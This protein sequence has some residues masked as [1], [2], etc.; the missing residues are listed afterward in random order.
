M[1][2]L[3]QRLGTLPQLS[4]WRVI[5]SSAQRSPTFVSGCPIEAAARRS[6][7][8]VILNGRPPLRPRARAGPVR[9]WCARRSARARTQ[10]ASRRSGTPVFG[11]S[12]GVDRGALPGEHLNPTPRAV[13]S[14]TVLTGWCRLRPSR[15]GF[16][17]TSVS[18][19]LSNGR[20]ACSCD[21]PMI[22]APSSPRS[23]RNRS[24]P[25]VRR[26]VARM[27]Y[28]ACAAA[29]SSRAVRSAFLMVA[30]DEIPSLGVGIAW[31]LVG[32]WPSWTGRAG[33]GRTGWP[34]PLNVL[35]SSNSKL[36]DAVDLERVVRPAYDCF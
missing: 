29:G 30:G 25:G 15:S 18:P 12:R 23:A 21:R 11:G 36:P 26:L 32:R 17:T 1:R 16:Q 6:L 2:G 10:Q 35:S 27:S 34:R 28:R 13:R 14:C 5:P 7:G 3:Q 31:P 9:R 33:A 19:S 22:G 24:T 8:G 4:V 20:S